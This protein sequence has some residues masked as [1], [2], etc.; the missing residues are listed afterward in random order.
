MAIS[1][2]INLKFFWAGGDLEAD[3]MVGDDALRIFL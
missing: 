2:D 3:V 1:R